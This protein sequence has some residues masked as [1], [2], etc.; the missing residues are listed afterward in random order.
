MTE[1][2]IYDILCPVIKMKIIRSM[3]SMTEERSFKEFY[4]NNCGSISEIDID[5]NTKRPFGRDDYQLIFIKSGP[6]YVK[7][8]E[9]WTTLSGNKIILFKPG[10]VQEYR[11]G[12]NEGAEYLWIHFAGE[13]AGKI[14][15]SAGIY[16]KN[17][18]DAEITTVFDDLIEAIML[19]IIRKAPQ[20]E[21]KALSLFTEL[22]CESVK[23]RQTEEY[24]YDFKQL[25]PAF[26]CMER[27][28]EKNYSV[29]D[30]ARMCNLSEYYFIHKFKKVTGQSPMQ[31]KNSILM[32]QA[33]YLLENTSLLVG[34]IAERLG[35]YDSMYFSKKF[36]AYYKEAP[37]EFRNRK[38]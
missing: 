9:E 29:L 6:F 31:Y 33:A 10:E 4:V 18:F 22:I 36:K 12:K 3:N 35:I 1:R 38:K 16:E 24:G 17:C 34:E 19:E 5:T 28:F 23:N 8:K 20:Y 7:F 32:K 27:E 11:C 37:T 30:Y 26:F 15:K 25:A 21:I 14:L 2:K 13:M